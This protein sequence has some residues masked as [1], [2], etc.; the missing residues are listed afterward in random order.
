MKQKVEKFLNLN[1][2]NVYDHFLK[3]IIIFLS[4]DLSNTNIKRTF[5]ISLNYENKSWCIYHR[6]LETKAIL[7][8]DTSLFKNEQMMLFF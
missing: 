7:S 1:L 3:S 8:S 5:E 4:N 6:S 2:V